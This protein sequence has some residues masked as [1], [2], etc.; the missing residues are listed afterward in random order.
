MERVLSSERMAAWLVGSLG[1][2]GLV[3]GA[4]GLYGVLSLSAAR[5][6]R[7]AGIRLALGAEPSGMVTM[8][9]RQALWLT[10]AGILLGLLAA[11]GLSR[12]L[13][14]ILFEVDPVDPATYV[15]LAILLLLSS[16]LAAYVAARRASRVNPVETLRCD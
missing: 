7:E 6:T 16:L 4:V 2:L 12:F 1:V 8:V 10:L 14:S 13:A 3:L 5:R 9:S 15:S 11:S